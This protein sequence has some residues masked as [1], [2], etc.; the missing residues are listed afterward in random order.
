MKLFPH[1]H[2]HRERQKNLTVLYSNHIHTQKLLP[3]DSTLQ[4]AGTLVRN[5]TIIR[6]CWNKSYIYDYTGVRCIL[7]TSLSILQSQ[8]LWKKCRGRRMFSIFT[9]PTSAPNVVLRGSSNT[10]QLS[11]LH[12]LMYLKEFL[13]QN[14]LNSLLSYGYKLS[15]LSVMDKQIFL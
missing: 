1:F 10:L 8:I 3:S 7:F 4:S 13:E 15:N 14:F 6:V 2:S 12:I 9:Y 5:T 11:L